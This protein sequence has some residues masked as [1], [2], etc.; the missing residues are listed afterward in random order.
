MNA[1]VTSTFLCTYETETITDKI[2]IRIKTFEINNVR[3]LLGI[4]YRDIV[5]NEGEIYQISRPGAYTE[6]L[7]I[8]TGIW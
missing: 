5:T 8:V 7:T 2:E 3:K 1:L 6:L 4:T